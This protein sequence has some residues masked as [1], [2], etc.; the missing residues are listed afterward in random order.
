M[1]TGYQHSFTGATKNSS[2]APWIWEDGTAVDQFDNWRS[3]EPGRPNSEFCQYIT[4]SDAKWND[5]PCSTAVRAVV[6][7]HEFAGITYLL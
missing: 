4:N 6:C 7:Q 1:L 3:G 2:S 5:Y